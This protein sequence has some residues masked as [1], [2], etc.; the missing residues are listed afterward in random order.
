MAA[1]AQSRRYSISYELEID[2]GKNLRHHHCAWQWRCS[3]DEDH[4]PCPRFP[5]PAPLAATD[6]PIV[7]ASAS[8]TRLCT[9]TANPA[10]TPPRPRPPAPPPAAAAPA[11]CTGSVKKVPVGPPRAPPPRPP[12]PP[13]PAPCSP[14]MVQH[15]C[16]SGGDLLIH[17]CI[18]ADGA[19]P[20]TSPTPTPSTST[21]TLHRTKHQHLP[22]HRIHR[23]KI[24][25]VIRYAA[26]DR[27]RLPATRHAW[28]SHSMLKSAETHERSVHQR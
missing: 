27:F 3:L 2:T 13:P 20:A 22:S 25:R 23:E 9:V 15:R 24:H 1:P 14:A 5:S 10:P 11:C 19:P 6:P 18:A 21:T 7:P 4:S 12:R 28:R 26:I 16:R 17:A 8:A